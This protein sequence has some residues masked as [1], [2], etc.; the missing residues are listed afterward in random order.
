MQLDFVIPAS[1]TDSFYSQLAMFRLALDSLGSVFRDARLVAVFGD[2]VVS[3]LPEKWAP[4]FNRIEIA[5]TD[6]SDFEAMSYH[7]TGERCFEAFRESA[8]I[9]ILCDADTL[10][11]RAFSDLFDRLIRSPA[12]A[13]VIAN[14]HIPWNKSSG[15]AEDDW[16]AISTAILGR[17][18]E[19]RHNY[20]FESSRRCPF[21]INW[22]FMAATPRIFSSIGEHF[23][24]SWSRVDCFL[25]SFFS[26]QVAIALIIDE[27]QLPTLALPRRFNFA[28]NSA[29]D[30]LYPHELDAIVIF[31][32]C[33]TEYFNRHRIFTSQA[34]FTKFLALELTGGNRVFQDRVR[35]ITGGVYPFEGA[36]APSGA[37]EDAYD[38]L[39]VDLGRLNR[40]ARSLERA[41][42]ESQAYSLRLEAFCKTLQDELTAE[43]AHRARGRGKGE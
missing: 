8:D 24:A 32:Y 33:S 6:C 42:E 25:N 21:Y 29:Y 11:L 30:D 26:S 28:N 4:Y 7:A 9:V 19:L 22:G 12:I 10:P 35:A 40:Y 23:R 41:L 17:G 37:V 27:S 13:G 3:P 14:R 18:I 39:R 38:D 16:Q 36:D 1:P 34:R 31:H 5:W 15:N 2:T 43:R 20:T